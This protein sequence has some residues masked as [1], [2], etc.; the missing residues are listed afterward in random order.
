[1]YLSRTRAFGTLL[2]MGK[3][4]VAWA[5]L[6]VIWI[7]LTGSTAAGVLVSGFVVTAAS[8][9]VFRRLIAGEHWL[10]HRERLV[11]APGDGQAAGPRLRRFVWMI[12][13]VPVFLWKVFLSGVNTAVLAF[14]PSIDFWPGIVKVEGG[15]RTTTGTTLF[16]NLL[17]LTPGTLTID[18]DERDDVLYVHWIDITGYGEADFDTMVTSGLRR[19]MQRIGA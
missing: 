14:R 5:L 8:V 1:M 12:A 4:F 7:V 17:T 11:P 2:A 18:Y 19:W 13:F 6:G 9:L 10:G 16:A 15:L 3:V